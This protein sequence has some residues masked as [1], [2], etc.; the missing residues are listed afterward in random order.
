MTLIFDLIAVLTYGATLERSV[1]NIHPEDFLF[2]FIFGAGAMAVLG[3]A[4]WY[5]ASLSRAWQQWSAIA[6]SNLQAF[7]VGSCFLTVAELRTV[8]L[9][10]DEHVDLFCVR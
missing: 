1:Y 9:Q 8:R 7:V 4:L 5:S 2:M 10:N 6:N 3:G